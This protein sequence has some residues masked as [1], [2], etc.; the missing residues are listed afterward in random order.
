MTAEVAILNTSAVALAADSALTIG[1]SGSEKIYNTSNKLFTLSKYYPLGIMVYGNAEFMGIPWETIIKTYRKTIGNSKK[2]RVLDYAGHFISYLKNKIPYSKKA[3]SRNVAGILYSFFEKIEYELNIELQ[4]ANENNVELT[5][6]YINQTILEIIKNNND[7]FK[8]LPNSFTA[9]PNDLIKK[10]K[11][12]YVL[13]KEEAFEGFKFSKATESSLRQFAGLVLTKEVVSDSCSG[14]VIT[15]FG[16]DEIFPSLIDYKIDGIIN[17]N[18]K[19]Q[20]RE[21]VD[22]SDDDLSATIMPFAQNEMVRRFMEG[23]DPK[24]EDYLRGTFVTLMHEFADTMIGEQFKN[25]E[26]AKRKVLDK[27]HKKVFELI[28]QSFNEGDKYK[29]NEFVNP[30]LETVTNLPKE[31]L[32]NMAEALVNLTSMKRRVSADKETVGGPI[33]V[34]PQIRTRC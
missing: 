15:G 14:V 29:R 24:Y 23:I 31:E 12:E 6:K 5:E 3:E 30:I 28:R 26:R 16:C 1:Q 21:V 7:N 20:K 34:V 13:A 18:L 8:K 10:F 11:N 22:I 17:K 33:E 25:N 32:A 4:Q 19:I 2:S 27:L 9:R